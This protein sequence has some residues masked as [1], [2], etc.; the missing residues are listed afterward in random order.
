MTFYDD[1]LDDGRRSPEVCV[2]VERFADRA[3]VTLNDPDKLNVLSA[4]DASWDHAIAMEEFAE[5]QCFTTE[6]F[7]RSVQSLLIAR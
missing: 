7:Q 1:L 2:R 6:A 4:A 3:V 5:P